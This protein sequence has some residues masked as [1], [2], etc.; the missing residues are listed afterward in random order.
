MG[1]LVTMADDPDPRVRARAAELVGKFAH[2]HPGAATALR[3]CHAQDPS[4]AVRKKA[5]WY[6]PGGSIH[7]RTRP[8]R[9]GDGRPPR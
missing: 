8:A 6:A 7:E 1:R 9:P 2:T 3:T 5:G 4:P